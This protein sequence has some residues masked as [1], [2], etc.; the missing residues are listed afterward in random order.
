MDVLKFYYPQYTFS[1]SNSIRST[2]ETKRNPGIIH[3]ILKVS[4][5]VD[6]D[7]VRAK[8]IDN[9]LERR[10]ADSALIYP[11][12]QSILKRFFG[13]NVWENQR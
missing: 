1:A 11:K 2:V 4:G 3:F 13:F 12:F 9:I 10:N 7:V 5:E 8:Y 6:I